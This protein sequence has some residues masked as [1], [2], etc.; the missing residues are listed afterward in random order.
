VYHGFLK[1]CFFLFL[2]KACL[3]FGNVESP[4]SIHLV[5]SLLALIVKCPIQKSVTNAPRSFLL[6]VKR[7]LTDKM[8]RKFQSLRSRALAVDPLQSS[9]CGHQGGAAGWLDMLFPSA[10]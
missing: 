6:L 9:L 2:F 8:L 7:L 3:P 5:I 4:L 1:P 10:L